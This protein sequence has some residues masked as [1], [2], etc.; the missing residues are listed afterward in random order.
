MSTLHIQVKTKP[1]TSFAKIIRVP[2]FFVNGG[3]FLISAYAKNLGAT[4]F[5]G[6]SI[7]INVKYAFGQ[8]WE[9]IKGKIGKIEPGQTERIKLEGD[10]W[11]VVASGHALFLASVLDDAGTPVQLKGK[12]SEVLETQENQ[13]KKKTV[14]E[15]H[16]HTFHA[17]T[18]SEFYSLTA[19]TVN[20]LA[21]LANIALNVYL[22]TSKLSSTWNVMQA[23]SDL[24][25]AIILIAIVLWGLFV[26]LIYDNYGL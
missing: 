4:T 26:Y 23:N 5:N 8:L 25:I 24:V 21:F 14:E 17:L 2:F 11:G 16:V 1:V 15:Y 13:Y 9:N 12:N 18:L 20:T 6:G 19:I 10:K 7:S 3:N 22:N